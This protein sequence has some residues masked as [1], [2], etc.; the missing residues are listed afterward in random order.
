MT[1]G[2]DKYLF[3]LPFDH[4]GSFQMKM[5]G[6]TGPLTPEQTAA[7]AAAKQVIYEGFQMAVAGGVPKEYAGILVDEQFGAAT[8][9][10]AASKRFI[11]AAPAEKSG[12]DEF[13]FEYGE[14]FAQHIEVFHPTF[15]KVLVRYNPEGNRALNERQA[16]RLRQLSE[17]LHNDGESKFMFELLVPPLK[18]QL[19]QLEHDK[20]AYDRQLRPG[21]MVRAIEELQDRGVEPD[22]WKIEGLDRRDDCGSMVAAA[23]R[24]G[25]D[26]VGCI[27]LG[28]GEDVRKVREWLSIAATVPGFVGFAVGRTVFWDP[29]IDWRASKITR[30]MAVQRIAARYQEFVNLFENMARAA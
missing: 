22:L 12:Q 16:K 21:L 7:V 27:V 8:L 6:W 29:L 3:I 9:R 17:Y 30:E 28:H 1:L 4:R 11:T 18:G 20:N 24:N 15:C 5:F 2:Y 26:H 19:E 10:D 14:D 25:R 23:R 13:D